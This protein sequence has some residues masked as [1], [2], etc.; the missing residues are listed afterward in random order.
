[1]NDTVAHA[2][3]AQWPK[4]GAVAEWTGDWVFLGSNPAAVTLLRRF[5]NSVYPAFPV[6]FKRGD[7]KPSV[8]SV[9]RLCQRK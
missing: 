7:T 5:G 6:Y 2:P 4:G 1:M 9:W 3:G 8:P